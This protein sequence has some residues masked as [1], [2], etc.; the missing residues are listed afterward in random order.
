MN[1]FISTEELLNDSVTRG[2]VLKFVNNLPGYIDRIVDDIKREDRE[3]LQK[4]AH[5]LCGT[6]GNFGFSEISNIAALLNEK[7][8]AMP[9]AEMQDELNKLHSFVAEASAYT[10]HQMVSH[11]W[12]FS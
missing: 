3:D 5:Q 2:V 6:A 11:Q 7:A 1:S 8:F 10:K 4:A 9:V 12:Y